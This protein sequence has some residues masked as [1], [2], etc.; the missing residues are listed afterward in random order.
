MENCPICGRSVE[1]SERS[2]SRDMHHVDC[3]VCGWYSIT[4]EAVGELE[5]NP[6]YQGKK[7]LLSGVIRSASDRTS[8]LEILSYDLPDLLDAANP[9]QNPLEAVDDI[10]LHVLN[11]IEAAHEA[12]P[13]RG[14]EYSVVYAHGAQ[15]FKYLLEKAVELNYLESPVKS[16]FRL[17]LNGWERAAEIR[18]E[19]T[20]SDRAFVAMWFKD[21]LRPAWEDGFKPALKQ[22][23][24]SPIRID[25]IE[26]N[27]RIDD[28]IIGEIRGSGLLV[29]DFTG[30]RGGVYFEA[31]FALGLELPVIWTCHEDCVDDLH[32]DTRQY[33]HIVWEEPDDLRESLEDRIRATIPGRATRG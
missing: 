28:R 3:S 16:T 2:K 14:T 17:T 19:V 29:A 21:K 7:Y 32:F 24:Y 8:R 5:H 25:R 23:G 12:V 15:E 30:N 26:H 4:E 6:E 1:G 10:L 9:P 22:T 18:E 20:D 31:G 27:D 33:N 11:H 13:L